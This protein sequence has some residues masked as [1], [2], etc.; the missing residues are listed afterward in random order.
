MAFLDH[1]LAC[2]NANDA[3]FLPI[4][5]TGEVVGYVKP[6][7]ARYLSDRFRA[8][9][10][11]DDGSI[12]IDPALATQADRTS[13]MADVIQAL[14]EEGVIPPLRGEAYPARRTWLSPTHFVYDRVAS[15]YFGFRAFGVHMNG[16]VRT[17]DGIGLWIGIRAKDKPTWPG[18]LDNT[19]AGG[20]PHGLS[21]MENLIKECAEEAD[22]QEPMARKAVPVGCITYRT[23]DGIGVKPDCMYAYD[24]ELPADFTPRNTDGEIDEFLFLPAEEVMDIIRDTGRFKFNCNLIL[25]DFFIRHGLITPDG[26]AD[27]TEIC[28]GLRQ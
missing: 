28:A 13:A 10:A 22:I 15:S 7:R 17:P 23:D 8:F 2:N 24:L 21:L 25:I 9:A 26:E 6:E 3:D 12:D 5:V 20:Q 14:A 16:Y 27:Y 1:I 18:M 19:V 11:R 4:R